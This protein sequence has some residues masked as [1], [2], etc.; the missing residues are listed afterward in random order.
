LGASGRQRQRGGPKA[1]G[2]QELSAGLFHR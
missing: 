1:G 2:L